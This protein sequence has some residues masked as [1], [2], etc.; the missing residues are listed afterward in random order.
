[1]KPD[2]IATKS[3]ETQETDGILFRDSIETKNDLKSDASLE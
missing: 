2:Q 1:L 3:I